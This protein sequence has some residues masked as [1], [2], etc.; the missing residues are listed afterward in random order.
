MKIA[1]FAGTATAALILAAPVMAQTAGSS[2]DLAAAQA[3]IDALKQQLERLEA[4]VDYLKANASAEHKEK[5]VAASDVAALKTTSDKFTWSGDFRLRHDMQDRSP[6]DTTPDHT[7]QR[8][9][10]RARFG[11]QA[12]VNDTTNVILR[13]STVSND[14]TNGRSTNQTLGTAWDRKSV[15][16][17]LAYV[18]W[19][20]MPMANLM[21][22]KMPQ[23][24]VK[25]AGYFWDNDLTPEGAALKFAYGPWF[26]NASYTWINE[27]N[28]LG[29]EGSSSDATMA[30]I[31]LGFKPTFKAGTLTAA[32]GYFDIANIQDRI[33]KYSQTITA[34]AGGGAVTTVT[35]SIDGAFGSGFGT[36]DN[37]FNNTEYG[38]APAPQ[39][40]STTSCTRLY[41]D[42]NLFTALLQFDTTVGKYPLTVFADYMQNT[43]AKDNPQVNKTLDG[44]TAFGFTF[45]KASAPHSWEM[46]VVYEQN[47][48]DAVF[49]QFVDSD[50]GGGLTDAKGWAIKGSYVLAP[51]L[52]FTG[53]AFLNKL[54]YDGV[55]S[56]SSTYNLDYKRLMLDLNYKY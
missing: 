33:V 39:I 2:A 7:R 50:F 32:V 19:K 5:A 10:I 38:P 22:G 9:Q 54:N 51:N 4:T 12:K 1:R 17:D 47:A 16:F 42:F 52:T 36:G 8:D 53:T 48:K 21:L 25:T 14:N 26:G 30:G 46:G 28:V 49:A 24:W 18:D 44:A 43:A 31:Q 11:V 13:L 15:G 45:N 27:R 40:G 34:P 35:C 6:N 37:S 56:N 20:P 23:P 29:N 3:Q 55:P 41:S